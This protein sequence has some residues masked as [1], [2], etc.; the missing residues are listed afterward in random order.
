MKRIIAAFVI[1]GSMLGAY[2]L[3]MVVTGADQTYNAQVV[4]AA[5]TERDELASEK[6]ESTQRSSTL[7]SSLAE[8]LSRYDD[9]TIGVTIIDI[10]NAYTY[11][12]GYSNTAFKAAST[13]KVLTAAYLMRQVEAGK[14]SLGTSIGGVS[15]ETHLQRML[16]NSDNAS[17]ATLINYL[18]DDAIESYAH[19]IGMT[20]YVAGD[21][22]T[23]TTSDFAVLLSKLQKSQLTTAAHRDVIFSYM[24][25]TN[26]ETLIPAAL[27]SSTAYHKW[28]LLWGNLHDVAIVEQAGHAYVV[29]IYTNYE[30]DT[31]DMNTLQ[32]A[33][34]HEIVGVFEKELIAS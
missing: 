2:S 6:I 9:L 18:G 10:D 31:S 8:V 14:L 22:N 4:E 1:A 7:E 24:Q 27:S 12:T 3:H 17:W 23:V 29:V 30:G 33:A 25:N 21:Y 26:N 11:D 34:I 19:E 16:Q 20:S 32:T 13:T 5:D 28:G 15:A